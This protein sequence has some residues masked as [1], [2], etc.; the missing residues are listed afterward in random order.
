[1]LKIKR[2]FLAIYYIIL[3]IVCKL[4]LLLITPFRP[5]LKDI[6]LISERGV[7]ARDNGYYF[8]K[9]LKTQNKKVNAWFVIDK[10]SVDY[11]KVEPYGNIIQYKSFKHMLFLVASKFQISTHDQGCTPDMVVFHY[12]NKHHLVP[13]KKIFLQHGI[14]KDNIKWYHADEFYTDLFVCS[15]KDEYEYVLN[16][17]GHDKSHIQLLGMCRYD[18]FDEIKQ[19]SKIILFMPTWRNWLNRCTNQFFTES[20]YFQKIEHFLNDEKLGEILIENSY[21]LLFYPHFESQKYI[22]NFHTKLDNIKICSFEDYDVHWLLKNSDI[23][24]TDYSS[25]F[26]DMAYQNKPILFYQFDKDEFELNHYQKGYINYEEFGK[27]SNTEDEL[28]KT[29]DEVIKQPENELYLKKSQEFFFPKTG[30][31]CELL[32]K[33]IKELE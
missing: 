5:E 20:K 33:A 11:L 32:W 21:E 13:G 1:M 6:W 25:V 31:N 12:L 18:D 26:F 3:M 24:I 7:D 9:Y 17:Y 28:I 22:K 15:V 30:N 16:N 19:Q 4:I 2:I 23:L 27:V 29:L 8:Y 14:I 10:K